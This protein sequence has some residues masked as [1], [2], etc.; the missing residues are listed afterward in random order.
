MII[1]AIKMVE[2]GPIVETWRN[3]K[4]GFF[5]LIVTMLICLI[6]SPILSIVV[7]SMFA[8]LRMALY[9]AE[10]RHGILTIHPFLLTC[11]DSTVSID[12]VK[13]F[14]PLHVD[15]KQGKYQDRTPKKFRE[16]TITIHSTL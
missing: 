10:L 14:V 9:V 1:V 16:G 2:F 6:F 7:G 3:D 8:M 11:A 5:V 12:G 13:L 4:G 15:K